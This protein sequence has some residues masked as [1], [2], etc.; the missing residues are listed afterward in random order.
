MQLKI[1]V[2]RVWGNYQDDPILFRLLTPVFQSIL[3]NK[4]IVSSF[5]QILVSSSLRLLTDL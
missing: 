2:C 5:N 4:N 1:I 3:K